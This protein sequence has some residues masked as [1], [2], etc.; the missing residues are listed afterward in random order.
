MADALTYSVDEARA[1][2]PEIRS[3]LLALAVERRRTAEAGA[4]VMALLDHLRALGVVVRDLDA[5]LV[6]I[7]TV[8][9][10]EPA[11]LC[12]RFSD[13]ELAWWHTTS[14]GFASRRPL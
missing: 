7:P 8:R 9:D 3:T 11:W 13:P 14:E 12:W 4:D 6:D 1:L 5:G 10:G 2:L